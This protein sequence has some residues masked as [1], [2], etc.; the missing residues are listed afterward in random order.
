MERGIAGEAGACQTT[1]KDSRHQCLHSLGCLGLPVNVY[2]ALHLT[3]GLRD[4]LISQ[5]DRQIS[6][7][8]EFGQLLK[9]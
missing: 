8:A 6:L 2:L 7:L 3:V 5:L 1:H 4:L 9:Y